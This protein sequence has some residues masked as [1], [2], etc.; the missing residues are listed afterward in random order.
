MQD[1]VNT[2]M[3]HLIPP[4]ARVAFAPDGITTP[5]RLRSVVAEA[6]AARVDYFAA[7]REQVNALPEMQPRLA[8]DLKGGGSVF[9]LGEVTLDFDVDSPRC[10]AVLCTFNERRYIEPCLRHLIDNGFEVLVLD[11]DSTDGTPDIARDFVGRGVI[12]VTRL[13]RD[14]DFNLTKLLQRKEDVIRELD[15]D[16]ALHVDADEMH[17]GWDG[18]PLASTLAAIAACGYNAVNFQEYTFIPT[19]EAPDHDHGGHAETMRHYYAFSK[20]RPFCIRAFSRP[21]SSFELTTSGGH[22]PTFS[23]MRLFPISLPMRHFQFL[24]VEHARERYGSM[25]YAPGEL[26]RGW[27][28]GETGWRA[29]FP[30]QAFPLPRQAELRFLDDGLDDTDPWRE[31]HLEKLHRAKADAAEPTP[32]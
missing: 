6:E 12:E 19:A 13:P 10:V 14:A 20:R 32:R 2:V 17:L 11:N 22:R 23:D 3:G 5:D 18:R 30:D 15:A 16:W 27:H 9:F 24:S 8:V 26:E 25:R 7:S 4:D 21:G 1:E 28:G 29:T 31:H